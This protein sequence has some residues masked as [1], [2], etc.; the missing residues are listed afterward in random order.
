MKHEEKIEAVMQLVEL[1]PQGLTDNLKCPLRNVR[2]LTLPNR[3]HY[4]S[5]LSEA[6]LEYILYYHENCLEFTST[7]S[8]SNSIS[9][10]YS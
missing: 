10:T 6:Q 2:K 8:L 9:T 7:M 1:C 3:S 5:S 4:L